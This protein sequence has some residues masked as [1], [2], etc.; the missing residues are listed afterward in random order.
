MG[1]A[2]GERALPGVVLMGGR[3]RK[4]L[5][6]ASREVVGGEFGKCNVYGAEARQKWI[7]WW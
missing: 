1:S 7:V 6:R 3:G 4:V 5:S 2:A